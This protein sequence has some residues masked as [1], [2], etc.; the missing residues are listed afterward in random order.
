MC[1]RVALNKLL[2]SGGNV[3]WLLGADFNV[4][5]A[6]HMQQPQLQC[7]DTW[8]KVWGW[9]TRSTQLGRDMHVCVCVQASTVRATHLV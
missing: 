3:H 6:T 2:P 5:K 8:G 9:Q 4:F 7:V 1:T